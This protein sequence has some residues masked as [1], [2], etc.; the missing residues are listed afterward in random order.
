MLVLTALGAFDPRGNKLVK[1]K[2]KA[3]LTKFN[4]REKW[5]QR[6]YVMHSLK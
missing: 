2:D 1:N 3:C 6:I 4:T 5:M